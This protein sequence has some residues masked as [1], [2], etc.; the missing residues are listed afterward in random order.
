MSTRLDSVTVNFNIKLLFT[1]TGRKLTTLT[2]LS[3]ERQLFSSEAVSRVIQFQW[4]KF[5]PLFIQDKSVCQNIGT[6]KANKVWSSLIWYIFQGLKWRKFP[7]DI[8]V[9]D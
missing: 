4:A 6:F 2:S 9:I 1:E 7:D 5:E 8:I 3:L